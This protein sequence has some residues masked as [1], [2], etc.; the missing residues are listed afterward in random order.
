MNITEPLFQGIP[1]GLASQTGISIADEAADLIVPVNLIKGGFIYRELF[2]LIIRED[3]EGDRNDAGIGKQTHLNNG[4]WAI[5][6]R[7][8]IFPVPG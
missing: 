7:M 8:A 5:F 2:A 1:D 3:I 6:F 4:I